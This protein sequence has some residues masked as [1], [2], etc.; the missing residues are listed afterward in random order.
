MERIGQA[1]AKLRLDL[2]MGLVCRPAEETLKDLFRG[3]RVAV[4]R[5][6]ERMRPAGDH[7]ADDQHAVAIENDEI[8]PHVFSVADL[9]DGCAL[10]LSNRQSYAL[11]SS[12]GTQ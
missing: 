11:S 4:T 2:E 1:T 12:S 10:G 5:Q 8:K 3:H 9:R 7:L 6:Q